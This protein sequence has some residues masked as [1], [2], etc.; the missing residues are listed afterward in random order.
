V[1]A[2]EIHGLSLVSGFHSIT[3][4]EFQPGGLARGSRPRVTLRNAQQDHVGEYQSP[5]SPDHRTR[6]ASADG[7]Y[8]SLGHVEL[9]VGLFAGMS[10]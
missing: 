8:T 4:A 9:H 5:F 10:V 2:G 3:R 6:T 7:T 1:S